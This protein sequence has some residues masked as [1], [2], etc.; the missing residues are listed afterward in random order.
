MYAMSCPMADNGNTFKGHKVCKNI[1][2]CV[3]VR[4]FEKIARK[5]KK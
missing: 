1:N 5:G 2:I 4:A 3:Y